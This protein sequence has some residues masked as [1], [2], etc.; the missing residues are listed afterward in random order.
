[1]ILA[2]GAG[3]ARAD[4]RT[5]HQDLAVEL[6]PTQRN[7]MVTAKLQIDGDGALKF[8][9]ARNFVVTEFVIDGK[10]TVPRRIGERWLI[11]L[12]GDRLHTVTLSYRGGL[13]T[14]PTTRSPFGTEH[15]VSSPEGSFLP[16][17]SGWHP[18]FDGHAFSYRLDITVPEP[19]RAVAPGRLGLEQSSGGTY[20]AV[21]QS[22]APLHGI[23]LMAGPYRVNERQHGKIRLRTYFHPEISNLSETYLDDTADY[24]DLYENWIG[25]YPYSAFH[26]VS[27][28]L[29]VGL[30]YPG[31]TFMGKRV[32]ALPFIRYSSLGHE[33][34][35]NW[36]GNGVDVN[37]QEG[38]WS[39]GLTTF[40]ADYT[41]AL[42]RSKDD[43]K[44]MRISWLRDYAAL[45]PARDRPVTTFVSRSHDAEQIIGYNKV[46]FIFHMLRRKIGQDS[47]DQGIKLFWQRHAMGTASW[48]DLQNAFETSSG[49]DLETF[50]GQWLNQSGAPKLVLENT[51]AH[52][53]S[54][55]F[56]LRQATR[57]YSGLNVPVDVITRTGKE[58]FEVTLED[59][60]NRL[61]YS[62]AAAVLGLTIDPDFDVF[63]HLDL[64]ETPP[65]L[66]DVTLMPNTRTLILSDND[67]ITVPGK[68]LARR[69]LDGTGHPV[70]TGDDINGPLRDTPILL[71]GQTA[72]ITSFLKRHR[73]PKTPENIRDQGTAR[74]W[75]TR[76]DGQN[77][78]VWPLA[79]I[80][81][82]DP[83]AL[84]ALL[85]P[86]P[87]YRR[88]GFVVFQS[89]KAINKGVQPS[90]HTPLS[91]LFK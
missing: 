27:G 42:G 1:M 71:I 6:N 9:L 2:L 91:V 12:K 64:T 53:N 24:L 7:L 23:V 57:G 22:E 3:S 84:Q 66:R 25:D 38:N 70:I 59:G 65:I 35:H 30:G 77:G 48:D 43:A 87:H 72:K 51:Q 41:F 78:T 74:A 34:L 82:D 33:V 68:H 67:D 47:F 75:A 56:D 79:V 17:G 89:A 26:I 81:V 5:I 69:L 36:W 29:P 90:G 40:M 54:V 20:R 61:E 88:Q 15:A 58:R 37:I 4:I 13:A 49:Q 19:Q 8:R 52:G 83:A 21:F 28:T 10:N 73:L 46:A 39:E 76:R 11:D 55:F 63:R 86:L 18:S 45:P 16:A 31:M 62:A 60:V 85:R 50:F 80:E 44:A 14:P 32:L